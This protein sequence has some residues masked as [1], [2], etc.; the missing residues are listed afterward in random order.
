MK[1]RQSRKRQTRRRRL[2]RKKQQ[3][4][5][6]KRRVYKGGADLA[7]P[8]GSVVGVDLDPKDPYSVPI[9]VSKD[10]YE[11]EVLED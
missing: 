4:F 7:V 11:K 5:S 6:R 2:S 10:L 1:R 9:L 8:E 3:F